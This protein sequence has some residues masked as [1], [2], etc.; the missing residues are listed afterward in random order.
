MPRKI[1]LI[2]ALIAI[3]GSIYYIENQTVDKAP[4]STD[5]QSQ[6]MG[7]T[8]AEKQKKY[9]WA[10][11]LSSI[12]G[13]INTGL[14]AGGEPQQFKIGD[15]IGKKV[16]L[17]DFWTYSCIN[18]QRTTPY[19]NDWYVKY[20]DLGLEII[21][22]HTP[23]FEFEKNYANVT[24][25][26]EK[27]GI[28]Y[29][30][31]LDNDFSTWRDY[32]NRY[33]PRKYLIDIDGYIVYDH[34]GEGGYDETEAKIQE[35]LAERAKALGLEMKNPLDMPVGGVDKSTGAGAIQPGSPEVY[36]GSTRNELLSNGTPGKNGSV[37]FT[38]PAEFVKNRLYLGGKWTLTDEYARSESK[39]AKIVFRYEGKDVYMVAR[40]SKGT[41][42]HVFLDGK[43][44]ESSMGFDLAASSSESLFISEDRLYHIIHHSSNEEH[45]LELEADGA[46][47]E[48]YTFTFG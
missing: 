2:L 24:K 43:K 37:A 12:D 15:L 35:L 10:Y 44:V 34:I 8:K 4:A 31:V 36:F 45:V 47:V 18:C 26:V 38:L 14:S 16:I 29:P 9:P 17:V 11:E 42:L 25:A 32:Q 39:G 40:A 20:K 22:V 21:G 3:I 41:L 33:W 1:L 48:V 27:F 6:I 19:L 5:G 30:V 23:E 28:K 7:M 13:Y 46:G